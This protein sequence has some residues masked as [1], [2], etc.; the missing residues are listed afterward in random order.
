MRKFESPRCSGSPRRQGAHWGLFVRGVRSLALVEKFELAEAR[1]DCIFRGPAEASDETLGCAV[2]HRQVELVPLVG[3]IHGPGGEAILTLGEDRCQPGFR[4]V[5]VRSRCPSDARRSFYGCRRIVAVLVHRRSASVKD[6]VADRC[7]DPGGE[8]LFGRRQETPELKR[9]NDDDGDDT[10][11]SRKPTDDG[12]GKCG[13]G[14]LRG[15]A[16][17]EIRR[18]TNRKERRSW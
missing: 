1:A 7:F 10:E 4:G 9:A 12:Q 16:R 2:L 5:D 18:E 14:E 3:V 11:S 13:H 6:V 8:L 15:R 17:V